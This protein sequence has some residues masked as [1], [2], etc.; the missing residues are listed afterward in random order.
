MFKFIDSFK[1]NQRA[2]VAASFRLAKFF[3]SNSCLSPGLTTSSEFTIVS[4]H[5]YKEV[6]LVI[7]PV[8]TRNVYSDCVIP[9]PDTLPTKSSRDLGRELVTVTASVN[10]T[11]KR[12][13]TEGLKNGIHHFTKKL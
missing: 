9:C 12:F 10:T 1:V 6:C 13:P 7:P 11:I 8:F 5:L 4:L 3:P 2:L